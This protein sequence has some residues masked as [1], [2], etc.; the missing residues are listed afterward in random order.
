MLYP[1]K[2]AKNINDNLYNK[3]HLKTELCRFQNFAQRNK[4]MTQ[5]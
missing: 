1:R 4:P 3:V 5:K 2:S